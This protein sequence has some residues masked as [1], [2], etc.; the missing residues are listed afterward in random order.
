M[1]KSEETASKAKII[2]SQGTFFLTFSL[3]FL[4]LTVQSWTD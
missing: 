2:F 1:S 3:G 4:L